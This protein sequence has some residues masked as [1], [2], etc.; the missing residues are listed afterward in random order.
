[1]DLRVHTG[2]HAAWDLP[3]SGRDRRREA[4]VKASL[5]RGRLRRNRAERTETL[6]DELALARTRTN[7]AALSPTEVQPGSLLDD[8]GEHRA[9]H[10]RVQTERCVRSRAGAGY[11]A[12]AGRWHP[13]RLWFGRP[14]DRNL[15]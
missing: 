2:G 11:S 3:G 13:I 7:G 1:M 10:G 14:L 12:T 9:D 5:S 15:R 4:K 6:G 8:N